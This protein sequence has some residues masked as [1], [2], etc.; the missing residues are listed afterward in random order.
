MM[1]ASERTP[2]QTVASTGGDYLAC[3]INAVNLENRLGDI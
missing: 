2:A 1:A 3:G